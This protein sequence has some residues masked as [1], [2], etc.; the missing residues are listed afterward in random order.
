[1]SITTKIVVLHI[2]LRQ[3]ELFRYSNSKSLQRLSICQI[4]F[5]NR[6][7]DWEKSNFTQK[8]VKAHEILY[9]IMVCSCVWEN[10]RT[11]LSNLFKLSK[12]HC[13]SRTKLVRNLIMVH[14]SVSETDRT[15]L[16]HLV[17]W[18]KRALFVRKIQTH[19]QN[20]AHEKFNRGIQLYVGEWYNRPQP[21]QPSFQIA[22][23]ERFVTKKQ[24]SWETLSVCSCA[25]E[26]VYDF[27]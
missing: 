6:P 7:R 4:I 13:L 14:S 2:N 20:K 23:T 21:C 18:S 12:E 1:M 26:N 3:L 15:V 17:Q 19:T 9:L 11:V 8:N 24:S 5:R 25:W 27:S 16:S 10:D 22:E